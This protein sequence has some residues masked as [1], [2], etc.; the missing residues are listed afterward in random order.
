MLVVFGVLVMLPEQVI[1]LTV[2]DADVDGE[3]DAGYGAAS[4]CDC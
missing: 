2:A 3:C 1:G 4:E